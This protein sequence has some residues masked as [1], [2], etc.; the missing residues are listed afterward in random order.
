VFDWDVVV[1]GAGRLEIDLGAQQ[2]NEPFPSSA[3]DGAVQS[4]EAR[5]AVAAGGH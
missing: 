5:A 1:I 4:I 2:D 3:L